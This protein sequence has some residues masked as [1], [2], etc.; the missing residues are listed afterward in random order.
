MP[1][2]GRWHAMPF[3]PLSHL[4]T[5]ARALR[6]RNFRLF[7]MGQTISLIGTWM[8]RIA[9]GW[10]VYKLTHSAFLLGVV[11]FS[12]QIPSLLLSPLAGVIADR[13]N[14][15]HLLIWTQV[16]SMVQAVVLTVLVFTGA[17]HIWHIIALSLAL[18]IINSFDMPTRQ[19]FMIQMVD[20]K[21]DLGNAI[22]L[23][24]SMVNAARLVGPSTAGLLVAAVGEGAVFLINAITYLAV[25]ASLLLMKIAPYETKRRVANKWQELKDG[26]RYASGFEPIRALLLLLAL[27]SVMGMPYAVLMPMFAK[28]ILHGG[29][30]LYG[31]LLGA[32]GIGALAGAIYL[33]GRKSVLGLGQLIPF[34]SATFGLALVIFSFSRTIWLSMLLMLIS[35]CGMMIQLASSN[36]LLQTLVDDDKRGRVMSLYTTSFMGMMPIGSLLAGLVAG[37]IGAPLTVFG[38]GSACILGALIFAKRLPVLR[39]QVLP[40]YAGLGIIPEIALGIESANEPR[41][42]QKLPED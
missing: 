11:G 25:I 2:V 20:D 18:G 38:G 35:G 32:S 26:I 29:P 34:A 23:N 28:D 4:K 9:L 37:H 1:G 12:G 10:L 15:Y 17:I 3:S 40:V 36:T 33:A 8:Q 5:I 22:A 41:L 19:A 30:G 6:Y 42:A 21:R 14:R 13:I 27:M 39:Q 16:L 24:S 7:F 31:F